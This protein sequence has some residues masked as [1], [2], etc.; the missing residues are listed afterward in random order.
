MADREQ[1]R[2]RLGWFLAAKNESEHDRKQARVANLDPV[3]GRHPQPR[4]HIQKQRVHP[5][6]LEWLELKPTNVH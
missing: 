6:R 1:E 5:E 3:V 4:K 2:G